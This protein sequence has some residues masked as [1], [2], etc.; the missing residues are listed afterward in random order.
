[1]EKKKH[2]TDFIPIKDIEL[3]LDVY[4]RIRNIT[5]KD[6]SIPE[7]RLI[8]EESLFKLCDKKK[9][10]E[11]DVMDIIEFIELKMHKTSSFLD[12]R[13]EFIPKKAMESFTGKGVKKSGIYR[14]NALDFLVYVLVRDLKHYTGKPHYGLVLNFLLEKK[15]VYSQATEMEIRKRYKR[16]RVDEIKKDIYILAIFINDP[17]LFAKIFP[18]N[19][20]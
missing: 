13:I 14:N 11:E 12:D 10:T 17:S 2:I 5:S 20:T 7:E 9:L 19:R 3:Y 16:L 8:I 4:Q 18:Q 1:M 6:I 15:F